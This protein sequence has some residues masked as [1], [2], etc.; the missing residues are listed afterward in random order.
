MAQ[1]LKFVYVL[2]IFLSLLIIVTSSKRNEPVGSFI[3]CATKLDCPEDM[4]FPPRRRRC[5]FNYCEC[6]M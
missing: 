3:P 2:M 6:V 1:I 5:A 4:C